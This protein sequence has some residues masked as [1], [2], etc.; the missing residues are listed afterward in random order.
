MDSNMDPDI[1][2]LN[3]HPLYNLI[4]WKAWYLNIL[5]D[6]LT[7]PCFGFVTNPQLNWLVENQMWA[8]VHNETCG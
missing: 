1:N 8:Q 5:H 2:L 7:D 6:H 3:I 4:T